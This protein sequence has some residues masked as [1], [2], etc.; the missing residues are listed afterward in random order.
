MCVDL[1]PRCRLVGHGCFFFLS[2]FLFVFFPSNELDCPFVTANRSQSVRAC[3]S[4]VDIE[5]FTDLCL[6]D[7]R[8]KG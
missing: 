4:H 8:L 2:F 3:S 7:L 6:L 1:F 5:V